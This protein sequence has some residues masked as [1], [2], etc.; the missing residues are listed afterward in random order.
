[1]EAAAAAAAK[2]AHGSAP[3]RLSALSDEL[4]C[5]VLSFLPSRQA[6]QTT[7]LSRR[8]MDLW[9]S[10]PA[11][12]ISSRDFGGGTWMGVHWKRKMLDFANNLL[13]LNNARCLDT[14]R[15]DFPCTAP[16]RPDLCC[17][18]ARWVR[19]GI[20]C[21][22]LVLQILVDRSHWFVYHFQIPRLGSEL[23]RLK[24][25]EFQSV[26]LDSCFSERLSSGCPVLEV[27]VLR[28]CANDFAAIQS[29]TLKNLVV[30]TCAS[31]GVDR[32][33]VRAPCL[34]S[35]SLD[36]ISMSRRYKNGLS[37]EAGNSLVTASI[38]V[39]PKQF[40]PRTEAI[41]LSSVFNVKSLELQLFQAMAIM[42]KELD[43]FTI[44][45]NLRTLSLNRC[46]LSKRDAAKFKALGRFLRKSPNLEKL[47][48][49]DFW[50]SEA[51]VRERLDNPRLEMVKP[52]VGPIE[53]PILENLRTLVLDKC[54][55]RDKFRLLR[56]LLRSSPNLEKLI[57]QRCELPGPGVSMGQKGK[58]KLKKT[59]SG[60]QNLVHFQCSK[61]K[62]TEIIYEKGVKIQELVGF[63]LDISGS[64]TENSI[65]LT[66]V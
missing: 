10:V 29:D 56:H 32:L 3:D 28:S 40:S 63:L 65:T 51:T 64:A 2:R 16:D 26:V 43:N 8:W 50:Y 34:A 1:M 7:M 24:R 15:L 18:A 36:F 38:S 37:L 17:D 30:H 21:Q 35:M 62:Y 13:M 6:V 39:D 60:L 48:L 55:L 49:K 19:H 12:R 44:F 31:G 20:K 4:L 33:V 52:V 59:H 11:I 47:I 22:P 54:D 53:F 45:E 66:K 58:A 61:L 5:Q 23:R 46:F 42:D 27:L 9:R 57:V 14:F 41:L 25:L